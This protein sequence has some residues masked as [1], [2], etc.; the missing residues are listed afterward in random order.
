MGLRT[1]FSRPRDASDERRGRRKKAQ[2]RSR[3]HKPFYLVRPVTVA[4][5]G[6]GFRREGVA[7]EQRPDGDVT[8]ATGLGRDAKGHVYEI[9]TEYTWLIA[10]L[11][12]AKEGQPSGVNVICETR[13]CGRFPLCW[14]VV[15]A[16]EGKILYRLPQNN[17]GR[18]GKSN[19][20]AGPRPRRA[21]YT[22]GMTRNRWQT[23]LG[24]V[25]DSTAA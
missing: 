15:E 11:P 17:E 13:G 6:G 21:R 20:L 9:R 24:N 10:R 8:G 7:T 1:L 18:S 16:A 19:S 22:S 5:S 14:R 12:K 4:I 25:A 23:G 2:L 3:M